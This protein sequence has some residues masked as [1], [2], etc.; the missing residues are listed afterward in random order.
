MAKANLS[1][2]RTWHGQHILPAMRSK[3][4]SATTPLSNFGDKFFDA[5]HAWRWVWLPS[6]LIELWLDGKRLLHASP[7]NTYINPEGGRPFG[8]GNH[9]ELRLNLVVGGDNGRNPAGAKDA[10]FVIRELRLYQSPG[11]DGYSLTTEPA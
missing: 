8:N 9:Q 6:G 7:P 10:Y 2:R 11:V 5:W 1:S 3:V 4:D